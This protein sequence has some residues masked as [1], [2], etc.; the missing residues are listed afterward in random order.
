MK[1]AQLANSYKKNSPKIYSKNV[2]WTKLHPRT[3]FEPS[4]SEKIKETR[5]ANS[6]HNNSPNIT[7]KTK[8]V[9][10]ALSFA[11]RAN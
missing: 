9:H 10:W 6:Y 11:A 4:T 5:A 2:S 1:D 3:E 8:L 7:K